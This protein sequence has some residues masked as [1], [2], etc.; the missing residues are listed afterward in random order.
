MR[1]YLLPKTG[2][3]Y[4]ANMHCHTTLSDG[5]KTPEE[6]KALY[7]KLGYSIVAYTDHGVFLQHNNLSDDKFLALNGFEMETNEPRPW[8]DSPKTCHIC[9]VA[10]ERSTRIQPM[11]HRTKYLFGNSQN[12]RDK[13]KFDETQP[14]YERVYSPEGITDIMQRGREAG[15]FVTYNHPSW[16][17]EDY[18]NYTGYHGMNA[19]EMF[20]GSCLVGGFDD[21]N[22]RVYDDILKTGNRIFCVGGD[23]N[24]NCNPDFSRRSDS[25]RAFTVIKAK[26]LKYRTV[27]KA[28][29]NGDFY[30]SEGPEIHE[31]YVEDGFVY[32]KCSGADRIVCNYDIRC[33]QSVLSE[34]DIPLTSA[35]FKIREDAKYFRLTVTDMRGRRACTNGYFLDTLKDE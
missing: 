35:R 34:N 24:H 11:W 5:R 33:A 26:N 30:A 12:Q 3:F 25:G 10:L 8:K 18:T 21:Y 27:T 22:P 4:K 19:M 20:N 2:N 13:I 32:I 15:F 29:E 16:S 28:L 14:D 1:K 6:V 31:L 9:F 23:D 17:L 7:Q